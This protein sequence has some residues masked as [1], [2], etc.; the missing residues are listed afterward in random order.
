MG[1]DHPDAQLYPHATGLA[2]ETVAKHLNDVPLKLYSGWFCI[3]TLSTHE[4]WSS[5]DTMFRPFCTKS[6]D[7]S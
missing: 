5:A 7:G 4:L 2:A 3:L 6:M 1:Q